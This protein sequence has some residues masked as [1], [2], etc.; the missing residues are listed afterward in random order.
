MSLST[1]GHAAT[2]AEAPVAMSPVDEA[3]A[4]V[5]CWEDLGRLP[6]GPAWDLQCELTALRK[7]G[8]IPDHLLFVEHPPLVSL[9]RN[10]EEQNLLVS[11]EELRRRG[12]DF[13]AT[14]RGGGVT[15]HGPGQVVG[16]PIF[17][18]REW[19]RDVL[20]YVRALEQVIIDAMKEYSISAGRVEGATGVW[21]DGAKLAA[22]GVHISRWVTSHG[23]AVNV[24]TDLHYFSYIIPCGLRKPVTSMERL[25]GKAPVREEVIAALVKSFGHVFGRNMKPFR[26]ATVRERR[27]RLSSEAVR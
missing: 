13:R 19:K 14:N 4:P 10:A 1:A 3:E 2:A 12:I 5:C 6:F 23:F 18:L 16:Y 22:I 7:A 24:S 9:G 15:Y 20:A 21:V 27:G 25:L 11:R 17:N 8:A 26:A